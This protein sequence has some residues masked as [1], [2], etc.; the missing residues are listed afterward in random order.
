MLDIPKK[1]K[2]FEISKNITVTLDHS[3]GL[4]ECSTN[5]IGQVKVKGSKGDQRHRTASVRGDMSHH[6]K[7]EKLR[8]NRM[9]INS[10][11]IKPE[12]TSLFL[13]SDPMQF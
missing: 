1:R 7:Q 9:S 10:R 13:T 12:I 5:R 8:I 6:V 4:V 11:S 3:L 2:I